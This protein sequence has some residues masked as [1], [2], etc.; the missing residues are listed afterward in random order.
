MG[1]ARLRR[2]DPAYVVFDAARAP[3]LEVIE[4]HLADRGVVLAGRYGRWTYA[5]MED[6]LT[7]GRDAATRAADLALGPAGSAR[8]AR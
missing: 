7:D 6:A 5:S 1:V 8:E 2:L 3:A 4:P